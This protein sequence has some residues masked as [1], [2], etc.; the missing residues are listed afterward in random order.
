MIKNYLITI[1][2]NSMRQKAHA[3]T[4]ILG[5]TVGLASAIL[6]FMWMHDEVNF[7]RF[8]DDGNHIFDVLENQTYQD[9]K[10][11][12]FAA[13]P[14]LLAPALQDQYPEIESVCRMDWGQHLSFRYGDKLLMETG[15]YADSSVFHVFHFPISFGNPKNP[16]PDNTSIAISEKLAKKY[17][18]TPADAIGKV[19][20]VDDSFD[21]K[22]TC[23]YQDIPENSSVDYDF[24]AP[25]SIYLQRNSWTHTW[26]SNGLRTYVKLYDPTK[27]PELSK[28]LTDFIKKRNEGSVVTLFLQSFE[29]DHL[30]GNFE[31]GK[32]AGGR[33]TLIRL[34]GIVALLIIVVA[35]IN[36]MNLSTARALNRIKEVGLRKVIGATRRMLVFQFTMESLILSFISLCL[37]LVIVHLLMPLFNELTGKHLIVHYSDPVFLG[38]ILG[39]TLFTGLLAGSYPSLLL[40]SFRPASALKRNTGSLLTGERLRKS[41][42]VIQFLVSVVLILTTITI[43]RQIN[44]IRNTD[45]GLDRAN[46]IKV[47]LG[48]NILKNQDAFRNDVVSLAS[49]ENLAYTTESP[50]QVGSSTADLSWPGKDPD[51]NVLI[52][53]IFVSQ[54]FI[55]TMGITIL[56]GRDFS[57]ENKADSSNIIV[58]EEAV[59]RMGLK[60][61]V[62]AD[63]SD[64]DSKGK[65]IGVIKNFH[66]TNMH[67]PIEPLMLVLHPEY[68]YMALIR[69]QPGQQEKVLADIKS[70]YKKWDPN[71]AF[72]YQFLD[73]QFEEM[74]H[75]DDV[76]GKLADAF[77]FIA[78]FISCLG[79]FGLASYAAEKRIKEIGIRK[80]L[81]AS[82]NGLIIMLCS[83]FARL[84]LISLVLGSALSYYI[85]T[86]FLEQY[87]FHVTLDVSYFI[88]ASVVLLLIA[89]ATVFVQ[90]AR[91]ALTNPVNTLRAE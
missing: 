76:L 20:R 12:T 74:Y 17:F 50:I 6:I 79:L 32:Q 33:I 26:G 28:K 18:D 5:L 81:G 7:D 48:S 82:V 58:N 52:Q 40:S 49:V 72:D 9:N 56:E 87:A 43:Y 2:R 88:Y 54:E 41:L 24:F 34:L 67:D 3:L 15:R 90:S 91:A 30:Y 53:Q 44:F 36:F 73:D 27:A 62:G 22:V 61:P 46:I 47:P 45:L 31:N 38:A 64:G 4:N 85:T 16:L 71:R 89:L 14:G 80:V 57:P 86:K 23:V 60:D 51:K 13:T 66:S 10:I 8:L 69:I 65:I 11:Y 77:T 25:M 78:I 83:D 35:C 1:L 37:A 39:I 59:K 75:S 70:I 84:I 21:L 42:V 19:F 68:S 63:I 29:Q 55:K